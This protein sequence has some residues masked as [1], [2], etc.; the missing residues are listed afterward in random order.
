M[1]AAAPHP[2]AAFDLV[3][4][5]HGQPLTT[6][7][8]VA[9]RFGKRHDNVLRSIRTLCEDLP[10]GFA[11]LNFEETTSTDEQGRKQPEYLLTQDGFLA[12][13]MGFTGKEA[14]TLRARFIE[15]FGTMA[16]TLQRQQRQRLAPEWQAARAAVARQHSSVNAVLTEVRAA[17]GKPTHAYH[18]ANEARLIGHA[19]TG[20]HAGI[21]RDTLDADQLRLLHKV[22]ARAVILIARGADY[23]TR[24]AELRALVLQ[25]RQDGEPAP[26]AAP[27]VPLLVDAHTATPTTQ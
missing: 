9:Q 7:R 16:R 19:L 11:R 24:K 22:E 15:A 13:A 27:A 1:S 20:V 25:E 8:R 5:D 3:H 17:A 14:A 2:S 10:P 4:V 21:D 12:L 23:E 18:L 26:L 6:S